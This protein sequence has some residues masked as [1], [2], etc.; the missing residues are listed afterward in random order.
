MYFQPLSHSSDYFFKF[1]YYLLPCIS[2][3]LNGNSTQFSCSL[4]CHQCQKKASFLMKKFFEQVNKCTARI[5]L[6]FSER[7]RRERANSP[8]WKELKKRSIRNVKKKKYLKFTQSRKV[9]WEQNVEF[10]IPYL[11]F[12]KII[13]LRFRI[14]PQLHLEV[15]CFCI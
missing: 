9:N 14:G 15:K 5:D 13:R 7:T 1:I 8:L 6:Q 3:K 4:L 12:Y 2:T 11:G 10:Q